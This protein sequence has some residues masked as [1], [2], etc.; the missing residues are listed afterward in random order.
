MNKIKSALYCRVSTDHDDQLTSYRAQMEFKNEQFEVVSIYNERVSGRLLYKRKEQQRLL[1]DCGIDVSFYDRDQPLFKISDR[2]SL[3]DVIIVANTSRFS[4]NLVEMKQMI[5]AL[6][7]KNVKLY[8]DDLSKFSDDKEMEMTLSLLFVLDES[9]SQQVQQ[10]VLH[11]MERRRQMGYLPNN[12]L[13]FGMDYLPNPE[14]RLVPNEDSPTVVNIFNDYKEGGS[15]RSLGIKYNMQP[16]TI[17]DIINNAK[18]AGLNYYGRYDKDGKRKPIDEHEYF[19]TDRIEPIISK[20]LWYECQEIKKSRTTHAGQGRV[21]G[22]NNNTY[23]L[24]SKIRCA[25]CGKNFY[26]HDTGK[27]MIRN[28]RC[29]TKSNDQSK[30]AMPDINERRIIQYL[31]DGFF[32]N[33]IRS[34]KQSIELVLEQHNYLDRAETQNKLVDVDNK[35]KKILDLY[36]DGTIEKSV[37]EER[38]N[39]LIHD[40]TNLE[41]TLSNIDDYNSYYEEICRKREKYIYELEQMRYDINILDDYESVFKK[42]SQIIIDK[43]YDFENEKIVSYIKEIRFKSFEVLSDITKELPFGKL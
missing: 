9:Y 40:K 31:K 5:T 26:S 24:S 32:D 7:K 37:Y 28:W 36:L 35:I 38:Y 11:G 12:G 17:N 20:E 19:E 8:F 15:C 10:K 4:R 14:N 22:V 29:R 42:V 43:D 16:H 41:Q 13:M 23:S 34:I 25:S 30:C 39:Q 21:R 18:Y 6:A 1:N 3:Y 27:R 33:Y 2:P